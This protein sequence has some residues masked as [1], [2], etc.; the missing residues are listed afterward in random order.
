MILLALPQQPEDPPTAAGVEGPAPRD[1]RAWL[2]ALDDLARQGGRTGQ[3]AARL[4][5]D[6]GVTHQQLAA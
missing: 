4:L 1:V 2:L 5:D 6:A 3:R